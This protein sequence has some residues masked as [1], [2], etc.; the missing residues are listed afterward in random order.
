MFLWREKFTFAFFFRNPKDG[1]DIFGENFVKVPA[2]GCHPKYLPTDSY[3]WGLYL[4]QKHG[5]L[6]S[7][8]DSFESRCTGILT[9]SS[10]MLEWYSS[11]TQ[12][13]PI[14]CPRKHAKKP[15]QAAFWARKQAS[16]IRNLPYSATKRH[17]LSIWGSF[18]WLHQ[19][20]RWRFLLFRP[21]DSC[22]FNKGGVDLQIIDHHLCGPSRSSDHPCDP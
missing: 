2:P 1:H 13:W 3:F 12:S 8:N 7:S 5:I 22:R 17:Y 21:S 19:F 4:Q 16:D 6:Q 18:V 11:K 9:N 15:C 20:Y 10:L 14:P